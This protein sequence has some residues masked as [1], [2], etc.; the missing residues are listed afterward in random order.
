MGLSFGPTAV[1]TLKNEYVGIHETI[2]HLP[3]WVR[4]RR[5]SAML[6]ILLR[7]YQAVSSTF[8]NSTPPPLGCAILHS[9]AI[10]SAEYY[11]A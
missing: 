9:I 11:W 6:C 4:Q 1:R 7:R 5:S 2:L 3:L 8:V 10:V